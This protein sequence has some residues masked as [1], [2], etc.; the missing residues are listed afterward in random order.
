MSYRQWYIVKFLECVQTPA[1]EEDMHSYNPTYGTLVQLR[2]ATRRLHKRGYIRW[3]TA[4]GRTGWRRMPPDED[5]VPY[6]PAPFARFPE[7][8]L[9]DRLD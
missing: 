1:T 9:R 2:S 3:G 4:D 7:D 6:R 5:P 8:V